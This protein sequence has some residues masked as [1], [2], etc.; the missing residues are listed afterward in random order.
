MDLGFRSWGRG[1]SARDFETSFQGEM[2]RFLGFLVLGF[3]FRVFD[4][5]DLEFTSRVGKFR[6]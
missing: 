6:F 1:F 2:F 4:S 3:E 5:K